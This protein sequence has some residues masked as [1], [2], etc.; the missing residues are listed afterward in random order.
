MFGPSTWY[1]GARPR[2]DDQMQLLA[3]AAAAAISGMMRVQ[4]QCAP[5]GCVGI[6]R[7]EVDRDSQAASAVLGA[8][9]GRRG[10]EVVASP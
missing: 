7:E 3:G 6:L 10:A 8:Y 9:G 5:E 4:N 1:S 2:A